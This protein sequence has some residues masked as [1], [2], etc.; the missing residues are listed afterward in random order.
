MGIA[1]TM[2]N[3]PRPLFLLHQILQHYALGQVAF[4]WHPP[5]RYLSVGRPDGDVWFINLENVFPL[6]QI[7]MVASFTPL[8]STLGI[9]HGDFRLMCGCSAMETYFMKFPTNNYCAD[10]ASRGSMEL[11][12]ECYNREQ[13]VFTRY[14]L[15]HLM[16]PF[17]E[18]VCSTTFWLS[19]CCS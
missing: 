2:E 10:L 19:H 6:L 1:R 13:R 12:S 4:S 8:Q 5:K 14:A 11:G 16:V 15:Q 17:C 3:S 7:S 9:A 18:L